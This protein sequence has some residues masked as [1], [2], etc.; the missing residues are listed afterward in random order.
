MGEEV[1]EGLAAK[2]TKLR[3][4]LLKM[5]HQQKAGH[6]PS[7]F[8][9]VDLL[10]VL[11]YKPFIK[12]Q[13]GN[14]LLETRDKIIISKGHAAMALYP[15]FADIGYFAADE[16]DKFTQKDGILGLY[17]DYRVPGIE[18]ISGSLG[19][20]IGMA[21]GFILADRLDGVK[22]DVFVVIGDGECYEG[23]IWEAAMFAAHHELGRLKVILDRNKLCIL[24]KTEELLSLGDL[25]AKWRA[26]G[27]NVISINGH[28]LSEISDAF[29]KAKAHEGSP[30]III[31][32]T[33]KGKGIS[34]MEGNAQWHNKIPNEDQFAQAFKDLEGA[35]I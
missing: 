5:L 30:T 10:T 34:F 33:V 18:G 35:L 17:A 15:I 27:W 25:S 16:L 3:L 20:G 12:Y 19:H 14:P 4:A 9:M 22:R 24:G 1:K 8:S 11:F 6:I 21:A 13:V 31:A 28:D 2:A 29:T 7:C 32:D 23:S 26:F